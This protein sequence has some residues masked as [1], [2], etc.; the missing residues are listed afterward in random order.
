[1]EDVRDYIHNLVRNNKVVLFMKGSPDF[2]QCGFSSV[3]VSILNNM[4]I[5]FIGV[6]VLLDED[7]RQGIK[8]Y[9]NWPTVPQLYIN[10][11]FIGGCDIAKQLYQ[12]G[13]LQKLLA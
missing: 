12:S 5:P 9:T 10:S 7:M 8:D 2:P 11:N 6:D 1:M 4:Q 13:E 3:V